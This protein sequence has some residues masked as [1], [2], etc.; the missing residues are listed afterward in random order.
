[1]PQRVFVD[2]NVFF[3]KT[4]LDWLLLLRMA[5]EGMF[6]IH[7]TEDVF[8]EVLANMRKKA[9]RAPGHVTRRRLELLRC[10]VD[11]ILNSFPGDSPFSG[12]DEHDYHI[13]AAA[14]ASRA[15][16]ILTSN[17]PKDIT[18]DPDSE[19]YEII[20]PDSFF[21]LVADSNPKCIRPIIQ[22]QIAY[23]TNKSSELQ[24]DEALIRAGC[25]VFAEHVR[26]VLATMAQARS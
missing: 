2:A 26:S 14:L 24:L 22:K 18:S 17:S 8:A 15:D 7:A 4:E 20:T 1:M 11:E 25:P 10:N 12:Q 5:N 3:S 19:P 21:K 9:P 16:L 6:Q 23:W 13:H